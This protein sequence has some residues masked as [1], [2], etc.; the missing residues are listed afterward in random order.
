MP[1]NVMAI[2]LMAGM[3][4]ETSIPMAFSFFVTLPTIKLMTSSVP[5]EARRFMMSGTYSAKGRWENGA[6]RKGQRMLE[7][8][9]EYSEGL[10]P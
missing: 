7:E 5:N 1:V 6:K 8:G 2:R 3:H 4:N 9:D 10:M